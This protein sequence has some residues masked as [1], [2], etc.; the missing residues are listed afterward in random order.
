[1]TRSFR[2][3]VLCSIASMILAIHLVSA[4]GSP[5]PSTKPVDGMIKNSV[6]PGL[7]AMPAPLDP[8]LVTY[9]YDHNFTYPIITS[10]NKET[11]VELGDDEKILGIYLVDAQ[12]QW[13]MVVSKATQRD[14][15]FTPATNGLAQ[16]GTIITT[17]RRYEI[18]LLSED[19]AQLA[20]EKKSFYQ[21]VAWL[22]DDAGD[23]I[24]SGGLDVGV[25]FDAPEPAA[26]TR[27]SAAS[28]GQVDV[29]DSN[30]GDVVLDLSKSHF[31]YTIK[32]DAP[33][34]P[35][36]VFDNGTFTFIMFDHLQSIP[37]PFSL[38]KDGT[39]EEVQWVPRGGY[40]MIQRL[41]D[42]GILLKLNEQEVKI[43]PPH[44]HACGLFGCDNKTPSNM[45]GSP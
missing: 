26:R 20:T 10:A 13:R 22:Y 41:A 27:N 23:G 4:M 16:T 30:T 15:F 8:H 38:K 12:V 36:M 43:Y 31:G 29:G 3:S 37:G 33:F 7:E 1:M 28:G 6:G 5:R 18:S 35:T 24:K 39:A 21:R 40:Y 9:P 44:S 17:K 2:S 34:K 19:L 45:V 14:V 32:G 25:E 11:H 42:Y